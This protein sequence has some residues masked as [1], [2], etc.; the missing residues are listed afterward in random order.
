VCLRKLHRP[1]EVDQCQIT[2]LEQT[3][4]KMVCPLTS[5]KATLQW[6]QS[7]WKRVFDIMLEKTPGIARTNK[8]RII[9]LLETNLNQFLR[10]AFARNI[11]KLAQNHDGVISEHQYGRS[12]HTCISQILNKLLTIQILNPKRTNGIILENDAKGCYDRIID[13]ISLA[14]VRRLWYS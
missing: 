3:D 11:M 7:L 6:Q 1:T 12:H 2:K 13:G 10:A 8:L 9:Q 5:M 14:M 4:P